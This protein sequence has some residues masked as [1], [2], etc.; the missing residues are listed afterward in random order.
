MNE[1]N[2]DPDASSADPRAV[3]TPV[4][5]AEPPDRSWRIW[6]TIVATS[7]ILSGIGLYYDEYYKTPPS[8]KCVAG[9]P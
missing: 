2:P 4:V 1:A 3:T 5:N 6:L 7:M 9:A 8:T